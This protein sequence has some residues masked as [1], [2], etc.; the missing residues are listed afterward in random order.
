MCEINNCRQFVCTFAF[1]W[2]GACAVRVRNQTRD[3]L[4][5][6]IQLVNYSLFIAFNSDLFIANEMYWRWKYAAHIRFFACKCTISTETSERIEDETE[7]NSTPLWSIARTFSHVKHSICN[8]MQWES[9][10]KMEPNRTFSDLFYLL[11]SRFWNVKECCLSF[12][13]SGSPF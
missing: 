2:R 11:Q 6:E 9:A 12:A 1:V 3:F 4:M 5:H 8:L 10:K 13:N 7:K